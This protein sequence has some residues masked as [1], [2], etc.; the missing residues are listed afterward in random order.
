[1]KRNVSYICI[2]GLSVEVLQCVFDPHRLLSVDRELLNIFCSPELFL[3]FL[4]DVRLSSC[5]SVNLYRF[6]PLSLWI[7]MVMFIYQCCLFGI[8]ISIN[9]ILQSI[10]MIK[11]LLAMYCRDTTSLIRWATWSMDILLILTLDWNSWS[12]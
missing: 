12:L 8:K 7:W 9:N 1:M 4:S 6:R 3:S 2:Y 11:C 5:P 10:L